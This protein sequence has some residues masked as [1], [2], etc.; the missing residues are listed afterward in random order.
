MRLQ[1]YEYMILTFNI[2]FLHY[3]LFPSYPSSP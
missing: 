3:F 1:K 2:Y